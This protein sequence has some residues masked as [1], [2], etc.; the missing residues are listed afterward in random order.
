MN[1]HQRVDHNQLSPHFSRLSVW[2]FS[3]GTSIG[4]GS[5]VVTCN[6]YLVQAGV[7]GTI[8]GLLL[9][10][11]FILV[12]SH[13]LCYMMERKPDAGGIYAFA[14]MVKD[15]DTGFLVAWF[16]LLTYFAIL[17]AN[18][19]S[20]PLFAKK[21]LG[22]FFE[23][24]YCYTVFGYDVYM[25]EALLSIAAI[26]LVGLLCAKSRD[27]TR[28][29]MVFMAIF[30]VAALVIITIIACLGHHRSGLSINPL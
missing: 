15:H 25:G 23:R 22:P 29:L 1:T 19:T 18:I 17:W 8:L 10:M 7:S 11:A 13:N 30:F 16:L 2:A 24:G 28:I 4:W 26:I 14:S 21:F 5:F 27:I 3:I 12:I 6:T 9:G 20:L